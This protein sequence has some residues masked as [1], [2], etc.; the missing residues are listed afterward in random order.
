MG[1][2]LPCA[3]FQFLFQF[4][5]DYMQINRSTLDSALHELA[6]LSAQLDYSLT[7]VELNGFVEIAW[8]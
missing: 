5:T 6:P 2:F 3:T 8:D 4:S 7:G 1:F